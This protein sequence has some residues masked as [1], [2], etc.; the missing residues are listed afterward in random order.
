MPQTGWTLTGPDRR[1]EFAEAVRPCLELDAV[2]NTVILSDIARLTAGVSEPR[3]EDCYGWWTDEDGRIRAAVCAAFAHAVSL[4]AKMPEQAAADLPRA[5]LDSGR[6]RP[7]SIFGPLQVA[8][9]IAADW[10]KLTGGTYRALPRLS[11]RLFSFDAPTPPV[12][13]PHGD[14]R[15]ATLDEV[16]LAVRWDLAFLEECGI[17]TN[18]DSEPLVR[19]RIEDGRQLMWTVDGAPVAQA[20]H[21]PV[22]AGAARIVGVY[23]PPEH[24][25]KGYAAGLTWALTH[26]ALAAG[27]ERVLLHTDLSNPTSNG[28]YQRLGYRPVHD[29]TEFELCG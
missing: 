19:A 13:A 16:P 18:D 4:S 1:F 17:A 14:A 9:R 24:R 3:A 27:A 8:E 29:A 11:M 10:A 7:V 6:A 23:T 22:I 2:R 26:H 20:S 28:V 21:T 15:L 5:W 12:P 25:R